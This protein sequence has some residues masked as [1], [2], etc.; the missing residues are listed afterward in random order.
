LPKYEW[1]CKDCEEITE[2]DRKISEYKEPVTCE[3]CGSEE[4]ERLIPT[5]T[6]FNLEGNGWFNK[7]GY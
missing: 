5:G 2:V 1:K 6:S 4:T 3:K 7:G